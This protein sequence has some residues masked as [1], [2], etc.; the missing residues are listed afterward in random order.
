VPVIQACGL[1]FAAVFVLL[2]TL[3]DILVIL[4]PR[5]AA[6][7][8]NSRTGT[9]KLFG[10]KLT[11]SAL[12][13]LVVVG[14]FVFTALFTPWIAPY[15]SRRH[16]RHLGRALQGHVRCGAD[17]IGR[18]MPTRIMYGAR[19]T[20][21]VALA[22]TLLSFAIGIVARLH[23]RGGRWLGGSCFSPAWST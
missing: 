8:L 4:V 21:G 22:I 23:Q 11:P 6:Q 13:G 14:I 3:A 16:R 20:I 5:P 19:M 15:P 7:A 12:F 17:Q 18:D 10:H 2:N 1:V 9:M